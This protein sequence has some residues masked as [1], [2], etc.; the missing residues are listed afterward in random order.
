LFGVQPA[1]ASVPPLL[2]LF[3]DANFG[4]SVV[5]QAQA[6][7]CGTVGPSARQEF[8]IPWPQRLQGSSF[9]VVTT[10]PYC[11]VIGVHAY[12]GSWYQICTMSTRRWYGDYG[13]AWFGSSANNW[14]NDNVD[15]VMV[16]YF[17][18]CPLTN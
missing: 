14:Y 16:G 3:Q 15:V 13:I 17:Y 18:G 11:N 1:D 12:G 8:W 9:E 6:T 2:N 5:A 10:S 7:N 4:G